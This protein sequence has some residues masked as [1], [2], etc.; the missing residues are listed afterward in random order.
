[1]NL[2]LFLKMLTSAVVHQR[3]TVT[4]QTVPPVPTHLEVLPVPVNPNFREQGPLV[5]AKVTS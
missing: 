5:P 2:N 1:M 4:S 3:T